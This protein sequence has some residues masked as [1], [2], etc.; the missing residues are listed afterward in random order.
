MS[1]VRLKKSQKEAYQDLVAKYREEGNP[2]PARAIHIASYLL[3][4]HQARAPG[5]SPEERLARLI[6]EAMREEY[7]TDPQGRRVRKKHAFPMEVEEGGEKVQ[8]TFWCDIETGSPDQLRSSFQQRRRQ[9]QGDVRQLKIDTDSY[10]D[11]NPFGAVLPI[12]TDFTA[13]M[14]ELDL[15]VKYNPP[16]LGPEGTPK[17]TK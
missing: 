8:R 1:R 14:V 17:K 12:Q 11:N 2:W 6:R 9:I 4:T 3:R 10:N 5:R 15:D 7:Y 13:D 16:P